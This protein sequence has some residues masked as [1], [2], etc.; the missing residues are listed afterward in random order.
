M[1]TAL[2]DIYLI[3]GK[4]LISRDIQLD[5]CDKFI[6]HLTKVLTGML[7]IQAFSCVEL[8]PTFLEFSVFYCFTEAGQALAFERFVIQCLDSIKRIV[9]SAY[10]R[11]PTSRD[12]EVIAGIF[13]SCI[14][15]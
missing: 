14:R 2:N 6:I 10:Y 13:F 4:T 8:I 9:S 3:L 15:L 12:V 11:P 1:S 7:Q 5:A